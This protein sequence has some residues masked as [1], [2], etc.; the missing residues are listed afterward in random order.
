MAC[1]S[2]SQL[3]RT[4]TVVDHAV[5]WHETLSY[6]LNKALRGQYECDAWVFTARTGLA[7]VVRSAHKIISP[8]G[9]V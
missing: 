3:V 2:L 7:G 6:P 8:F 1:G 5:D 9:V 4:P